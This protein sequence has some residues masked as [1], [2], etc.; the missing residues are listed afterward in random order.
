MGI[1]PR[2]VT[3]DVTIAWDGVTQRLPKGQVI[4]VAPGSPLEAA[5]GLH[6]LVPL[7]VPAAS[8]PPAVPPAGAAPAEPE[9][10]I[11]PAPGP[12]TDLARVPRQRRPP[13]A[14]GTHGR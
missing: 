11:T 4:D 8:P 6:R 2:V 3:Q 13:A 12:A 14:G 1:S 7:G 10:I 5:I 9:L